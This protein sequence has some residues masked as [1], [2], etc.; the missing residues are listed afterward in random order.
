MFV[1]QFLVALALTGCPLQRDAGP[2][3]AGREA[4]AA[5]QRAYKV[6]EECTL[7][8]DRDPK[9]AD[10]LQRRGEANFKAGRF[11]EAVADFDAYLR[12]KPEQKPY[13]W[14]R[15]IALYYAKRYADGKKQ[16]E[17]HQTVNP[18]DV[19]NAVWHFLCTV[20][21]E[22]LEAAR[23]QLIPIEGDTRVPMAQVHRL[24]AGNAS[25]EDVMAAAQAASDNGRAGEPLFYAH[26]YLGLYYDATGDGKKARE[27]IEKAAER[28]D[29][30]GYMGDVGRVHA[31]RLHYQSAK[32]IPLGEG[33]GRRAKSGEV[34]RKGKQIVYHLYGPEGGGPVL[35]K[36]DYGL[37]VVNEGTTKRPKLLIVLAS[38]KG[39]RVENL[40]SLAAFRAGLARLPKGAKLYV[41][42][43][44]T[45]SCSDGLPR[46]AWSQVRAVCRKARVRLM[47][48]DRPFLTCVAEPG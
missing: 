14:Q 35:L 20:R 6:I 34:N 13:H 9:N 31:G 8:L 44:C 33:F 1:L 18:N 10:A 7:A 23:K 12:L 26:L 47:N 39:K 25:P 42:D 17:L 45:S 16:F 27:H 36:T 24:F 22:G 38:A 3:Q 5:V 19:E 32:P 15:G 11:S 21:A 43:R 4:N 28:A 2:A 30:N 37:M 41:Y 48:A 46:S 40:D 29:R